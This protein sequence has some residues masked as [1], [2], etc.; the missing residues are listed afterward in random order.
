VRS[1]LGDAISIYRTTRET[2]VANFQ[3]LHG[4]EG[5]EVKEQLLGA[6]GYTMDLDLDKLQREIE[7]AEQY[8]A[9]YRLNAIRRFGSDGDA[10]LVEEQSTVEETHFADSLMVITFAW[11]T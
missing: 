9:A 8:L 1:I 2:K 10:L 7:H 6:A 3:K 4:L 5:T 11:C